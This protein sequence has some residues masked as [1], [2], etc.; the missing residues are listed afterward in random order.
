VFSHEYV[1]IGF[2]TNLRIAF[3]RMQCLDKFL[4]IYFLLLFYVSFLRIHRYANLRILKFP[5]CVLRIAYEK[6]YDMKICENECMQCTK[7]CIR[8]LAYEEMRCENV[9]G[10]GVDKTDKTLFESVLF[11]LQL[12]V[13]QGRCVS[14]WSGCLIFCKCRQH[15]LGGKSYKLV[16]FDITERLDMARLCAATPN[17]SRPW[18]ESGLLAGRKSG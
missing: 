5:D 1:W 10:H 7:L 3:L 13:R 15:K 18:L 12:D 6:K 11:L 9:S 8:R 16:I 2:A 17:V 4:Y 14:D